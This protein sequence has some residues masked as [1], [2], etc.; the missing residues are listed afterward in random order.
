MS[1]AIRAQEE[2]A[3]FHCGDVCQEA[4][5]WQ[6]E[7]A[8]CCQGCQTV[9]DLLKGHALTGYYTVEKTPGRSRKHPAPAARYAFL[10]QP[11]LARAFLTFE[12]GTL[13]QATFFL[14]A[15]HCSACIWLL[16][17]LPA[18]QPGVRQAQVRFAAKELS[19]TF[20]RDAVSLRELAELLDRLGYPPDLSGG[21]TG[22][23]SRRKVDRTFVLKIG[24]AGFCFGNIMLLSLPDYLDADFAVEPLFQRW[25]GALNFL[26]VLP[27]V[28]YV[29]SDYFKSAWTGLRHGFVNLDVPIVL[30]IVALFG[31]S[32]YELLT[33]TGAGYFDSLAGLLFFLMLGKWYQSQTYKA[34]AYDRDY[35][36]YFPVAVTRLVDGVECTTALKDL[37][38][39]DW[40]LIRH[41]ELIPADAVLRE[42]DAH[43]DYSFV[44]G[45]ATP[46]EKQ[47]GEALFAG[48]R[49]LGGPLVLELQQ[50]VANSYLTRLWN[51]EVFQKPE[52]TGL[53]TMADG[54]SR[55]FTLTILTISALTALYWGWHQPS[56]IGPAVTAV[57]IVAC[58]C[59]LALAAPFAL[60]HTLRLFGKWGCYVKNVGVLERLAQVDH[61][62]FDKT[63]TLTETQAHRVHYEGD[64]LTAEEQRLLHATVRNSAHPLSK[65]IYQAG[66]ASTPVVSLTA[67]EEHT[68]RGMTASDGTRTLRLGAASFVGGTTTAAEGTQV[69]VAV[70][71]VVKGHFQVENTYRRG[72][73]PL[74]ET[75]QTRYTTHLLSGDG[76]RERT[77]LQPYF[78]ALHFRQS[79]L[80]KLHYLKTLHQAGHRTLMVGDG[81]NDAGALKQSDVGIAVADDIYHFSPACDAI[82]DARQLPHLDRFLQLA[83]ASRRTVLAA[84]GLSFVYNG[85]GL[86][87][88]VTGQLTPLV[89]AIL[90]PLSS[91]TVVGF[92]TV[93]TN[94]YARRLF[95]K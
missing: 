49:Q 28:F 58:P 89:A 87:F 57:L 30:G 64:P 36:S 35:T 10:D 47:P 3:C 91:V 56:S 82:L 15:I 18:L 37:R 92:V 51:Q 72:L 20:D 1:T 14:P 48:G 26:L 83:K 44:T 7:H 32:V 59:A 81:L 68:G 88:A 77:R 85:V 42:G 9:Y 61:L 71:G 24:V 31:Q 41:Q 23:Q 21:A 84:F 86:A 27:V 52:A 38:A 69:F 46:I 75:L 22:R 43:I 74:L 95:G 93:L 2:I 65:A 29:A 17:Q 55:Y 4:P 90:M 60:G 76:E 5:R 79:P 62:V 13:G 67:F 12:E 40:V 19:V 34:L 25:F 73:E 16:E 53:S 39:G 45:E 94:A 33:D 63:G 6:D 78:S 50:P 8:F 70:D 80:D 54:L 11:D 66:A